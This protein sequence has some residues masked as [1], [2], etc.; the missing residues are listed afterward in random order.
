MR[1]HGFRLGVLSI[2]SCLTKAASQSCEHLAA[3]LHFVLRLLRNVR[4]SQ[5]FV[6]Q[7]RCCIAAVERPLLDLFFLLDRPAHITKGTLNRRK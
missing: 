3:V 4:Q 2:K 6:Q 7:P 1:L 5:K